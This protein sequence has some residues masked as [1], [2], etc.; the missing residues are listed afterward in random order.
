MRATITVLLIVA[1]AGSAA[2][3]G[4]PPISGVNFAPVRMAGWQWYHNS[5]TADKLEASG[6]VLLWSSTITS[7]AGLPWLK[8][9]Q[10]RRWYV[11]IACT[12]LGGAALYMAGK[13]V[14]RYQR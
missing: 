14:E 7:L 13:L 12:Y 8:E 1:S 9:S 6:A 10:R 4:I 5:T 2:Y 11:P 3:L